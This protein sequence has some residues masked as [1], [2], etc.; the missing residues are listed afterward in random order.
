[1][2]PFHN[3]E[4]DIWL[5][6]DFSIEQALQSTT[7]LAIGAHQDDLEFM[8]YEGISACFGNDGNW[9]TGVTITDGR[10]SSR[11]G[12]Y[13]SYNNDEIRE[14]R[15]EEQ[16]KAADIGQYAAQ[17]QLDYRSSQI[18]G[19]ERK[20][21]TEDIANILLKMRPQTVYL[22]QP[23]DKHDTHVAVMSASIEALRQTANHHIPKRIIGCEVWRGLDWLSD[24]E[25]VP[26]DYGANPELFEKLTL[27]FDSQITGGKRYDLAVQGRCRANATFFDS[28]SPDQAELI[29]W[30]IDL[31]PLIHDTSLTISDFILEH[32][33]QLTQDVKSRVQQ[34]S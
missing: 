21:V 6:K 23:A 13:S 20:A 27:T 3:T 24:S 5:N 25:K 2:L 32:L 18:K 1:M 12:P 16:R 29:T 28:H 33:N 11:V 34:F 30:G 10:G 7:H 4:T 9:F 14:I 19:P 31:T 22:H 17:F 15:R 8:A 26:M